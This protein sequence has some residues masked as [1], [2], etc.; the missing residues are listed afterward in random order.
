MNGMPMTAASR[1]FPIPSD[2]CQKAIEGGF[3]T[4]YSWAGMAAAYALDGKTEEAKS[5]VTEALRLNPK[6]TVKWLSANIWDFP[7]YL[8]G[9]RKGGMP[10]E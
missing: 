8:D 10:E 1:I 3:R 9:L 5:A 2:E 6:L 4:Q 7:A